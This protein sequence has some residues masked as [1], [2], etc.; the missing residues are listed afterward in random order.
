MALSLNVAG[1]AL[2]RAT[3]RT[4]A[5]ARVMRPTVPPVPVMPVAATGVMAWRITALRAVAPLPGV[6]RRSTVLRRP[7][8]RYRPRGRLGRPGIVAMR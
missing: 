6:R 4:R 5:A 3:L 7:G 2:C 1:L 8:R